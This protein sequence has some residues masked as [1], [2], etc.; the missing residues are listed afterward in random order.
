MP[1]RPSHTGALAA[2]EAAALLGAA[3]GVSKIALSPKADGHDAGD[4]V[5]GNDLLEIA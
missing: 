4:I 3:L 2:I 5:V 1:R